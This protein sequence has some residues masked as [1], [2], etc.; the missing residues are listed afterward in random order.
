M[1]NVQE[2]EIIPRINALVEGKVSYSMPLLKLNEV[3]RGN[4]YLLY[5]LLLVE[6]LRRNPSK[7]R[8]NPTRREKRDPGVEM[9]GAG[10]M[11]CPDITQ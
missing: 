8:V 9:D 3:T 6:T 10:E 4:N 2:G 11:C 5:F 1:R 7:C